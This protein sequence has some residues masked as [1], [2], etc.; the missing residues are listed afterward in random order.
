MH[1]VFVSIVASALV[2]QE[3]TSLIAAEVSMRVVTGPC[4]LPERSN[5]LEIFFNFCTAASMRVWEPHF[6]VSG[7]QQLRHNATPRARSFSSTV[8]A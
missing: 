3:H 4:H 7:Q 8:S 5:T 6:G 1:L 2:E